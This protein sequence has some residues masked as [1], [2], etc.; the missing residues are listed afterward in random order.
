MAS[1]FE[2]FQKR[3]LISS[4]F[5]VILSIFIVLTLLGALG[6]F[7]INTEKISGY[8]KEN[9]P[10]TV[11][12]KREAT[13]STMQAFGEQLKNSPFIKDFKYVSKEEAAENN[14]DIMGDYETLLDS[15]PLMNSYDLH[16][17]GGY[18][19]NDSIKNIE[20]QFRSN[21]MVGD[22]TYDMV[23]VE[24]A[25][26][27]IKVISFWI[28][29]ISG[30]LAFVSMLLINSS[31]RLSIYNHRFTIKTMQMVGATKSFIRRPFV[32]R[33]IKLG[34]IG[35]LLA[36]GALIWLV[37][38]LDEAFPVL[39]IWEDWVPTAIVFAGVLAF[40]IIIAAISTFF[41]T[42]RFLNLRTDDLY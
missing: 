38:Y 39:N 11:Y 6:L 17:K 1:S 36:I 30:V 15:N 24:M 26:E 5:S 18:V 7:V 14:R 33:G 40:G 41:A 32:W 3:R 19:Q 9:I 42:Q 34:L 31:L 13:D 16:L 10:M 8:V 21:P 20:V 35:S 37:Y 25:N 4:Y 12:F 2:K 29:V 28:L 22:I 23:L 27:N